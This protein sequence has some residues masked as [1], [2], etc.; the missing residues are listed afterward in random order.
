MYLQLHE[1]VTFN[2]C[3]WE[4]ILL[5]YLSI[6]LSHLTAV[7]NTPPPHSPSLAGC[8]CSGCSGGLG[9]DEAERGSTAVLSLWLPAPSPPSHIMNNGRE[10]YI[11][12]LIAPAPWLKPFSLAKPKGWRFWTPNPN[13]IPCHPTPDC[14]CCFWSWALLSVLEMGN[15]AWFWKGQA[16]FWRGVIPKFDQGGPRSRSV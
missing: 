3:V 10:K 12:L 11:Y 4:Y 15:Q 1:S 13:P 6:S 2:L 16:I 5:H 14:L 7:A 9:P 8:G